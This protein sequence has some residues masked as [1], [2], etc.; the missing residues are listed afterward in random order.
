MDYA[1][2]KM[3]DKT[4]RKLPQVGSGSTGESHL[5]SGS[6][7]MD[8]GGGNQPLYVLYSVEDDVFGRRDSIPRTPPRRRTGSLPELAAF[9]ETERQNSTKKRRLM[10]PEETSKTQMTNK[11]KLAKCLET[12]TRCAKDLE[13]AVSQTYKC[14]R[15][16]S[17]V[18]S[19]LSY[20]TE[21]LKSKEVRDWVDAG[22]VDKVSFSSLEHTISLLQEENAQMRKII[23]E[24]EGAFK[25]QG[26]RRTDNTQCTECTLAQTI[27][28]RR[29]QLREGLDINTFESI[30]EGEWESPLFQTV[31][32]S[33]ENLWDVTAEHDIVIPCN[34]NI[35]SRN[36]DINHAISMFGGKSELRLQGKKTGETAIMMHSISFPDGEGKVKSYSKNIY[37]PIA[38]NEGNNQRVNLWT[39]LKTVKERMLA[40][41]RSKVAV[42]EIDDSLCQ[43]TIRF[44]KLLLLDTHIQ[45]VTCK[46]KKTKPTYGQ[47]VAIAQSTARTGARPIK[48][49]N[50]QS[51][52]LKVKIEGKS[53]AEL[54]K[55]V[56]QEINPSALGVEVTS[57]RQSRTGDLLVT[58]KDGADNAEKLM[59]EIKEKFPKAR[60]IQATTKKVIHLKGMDE[61]TSKEEVIDAVVAE[62]SCKPE[63]CE[64][65]SMRPS[66]GNRQ[67]AT[68]ILPASDADRLTQKG[69][70]KIG[71]VMCKLYERK[72]EE[73]CYRCW[74]IGHIKSQCKGPDRG[75]LCLRCGKD[76]HKAKECKNNPYCIHC[77]KEGH[78]TNSGKCLAA[79]SRKEELNQDQN[80]NPSN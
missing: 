37:Y 60:A 72:K 69:K 40:E 24:L 16:F 44:L 80:K 10:S 53:Y 71:W 28:H 50:S 55:T 29:Q 3:A 75:G 41:K 63:L 59:K 77:K 45:I 22:M 68:V 19:Q 5:P 33:E 49:S 27:Y 38:E 74:E 34:E 70:L 79:R 65:T 56:K 25:N 17:E 66:Y 61:L 51:G 64:V 1:S 54:L 9:M 67:N 78:Q 58:V 18:S 46:P 6:R 4:I 76:N 20:A 8:S 30:K 31:E 32:V 15:E 14:K 2:N 48:Q 52:V 35:A 11:K 23:G 21:T 47:I 42:L 26:A 57:L 73:K 36:R 62:I 12:I 39:S 7:L 13:I 43:E